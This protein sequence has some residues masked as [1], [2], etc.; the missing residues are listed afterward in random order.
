MATNPIKNLTFDET[1]NWYNNLVKRTGWILLSIHKGESKDAYL[2]DITDIIPKID[3][4]SIDLYD[5]DK[6]RDL[7]I[8][9]D[10]LHLW[11][12]K[13]PILVFIIFVFS[14]FI[15]LYIIFLSIICSI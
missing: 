4:M 3:K 14:Y 13:M 7:I 1:H 12:F 15:F 2:K 9:R 8:M 5:S 6:K 10:N 11:T